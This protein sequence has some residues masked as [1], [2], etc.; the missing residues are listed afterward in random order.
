[1]LIVGMALLLNSFKLTNFDFQA[2]QQT[3]QL[4]WD[5]TAFAKYN[6]LFSY[7]LICW[8]IKR[9][10]ACIPSWKEGEENRSLWTSNTTLAPMMMMMM[11][12]VGLWLGSGQW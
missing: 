9:F 5:I 11:I 3:T 10:N 7:R 2:D 6:F 8:T 1:M 12:R 4:L